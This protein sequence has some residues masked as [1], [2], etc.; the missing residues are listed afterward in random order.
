MN[1]KAVIYTINQEDT[2]FPS[3]SSISPSSL[4]LLLLRNKESTNL[5]NNS[6]DFEE[7]V[8]TELRFINSRQALKL[9]ND[10][11]S[12]DA[13]KPDSPLKQLETRSK[14]FL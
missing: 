2:M 9:E 10:Y 8:H 3:I 12:K 1:L 14:Y 7:T 11:L 6:D 4:T 5:A 13:R